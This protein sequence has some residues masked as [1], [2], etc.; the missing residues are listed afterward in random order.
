[1]ADHWSKLPSPKFWDAVFGKSRVLLLSSMTLS[2]RLHGVTSCYE[3]FKSLE[4]AFTPWFGVTR[5][6]EF[7]DL[8]AC[9]SFVGRSYSLNGKLFAF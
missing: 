9:L 1:M 2:V 8:Y 7:L 4:N 3:K 5:M 6:G